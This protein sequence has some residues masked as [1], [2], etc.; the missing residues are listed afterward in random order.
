VAELPYRERRDAL[1]RTLTAAA[2]DAESKL[3]RDMN[4]RLHDER[5]RFAAHSPRVVVVPQW[6]L[7]EYA[8]RWREVVELGGGEGLVAVA[9]EARMGARRSKLKVKQTD[10]LDATIVS[11]EP[12]TVLAEWRGR[13][14]VLGRRGLDL[15][16]GDIVEVRH[17]GFHLTDIPR[18]A[19]IVR[20][21]DDLR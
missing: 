9:T 4:G 18:F 1:Y 13:C 15:Q 6:P 16:V 19:S 14:I 7:R 21:R 12:K 17:N 10:T 2:I 20:V 5:G 11:I 8:A 3:A